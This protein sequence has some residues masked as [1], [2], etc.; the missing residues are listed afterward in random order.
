MRPLPARGFPRALLPALQQAER[1]AGSTCA[2]DD[3]RLDLTALHSISIDDADTV[4]VD[5]AVAL[6]RNPSGGHRLWVHVADPEA[7]L[8]LDDPLVAEA[9]RRGSSAYLGHGTVPMFPESLARGVF[10][11]RPATRC[12]AFSFWLDLDDNDDP[13]AEGFSP[14]W[15][16]V[17]YGTTYQDVDELLELAPPQEAQLLTMARI[18]TRLQQQRR[19]VGA[20]VLEQPEARFRAGGDG[21]VALRVQEPSPARRLVAECMLAAGGIAGRYGQRHGLPLPYRSQPASALPGAAQLAACSPGAVRNGV[22]KACLQPSSSGTR[23]RPHSSLGLAAY[24]QVTSPIRRFTDMLAH[25]QLRAR[26]RGG[27]WLAEAE[28]QQWLDRSLVGIRDVV[29]L[30]KEDRRYWLHRWLQ[31]HG[32]PWRGCF[33]RWLRESEQ[34]GLAWCEAEALELPCYGTRGLR[35]DDPLL[36]TLRQVDPERGLLRIQAERCPAAS[37]A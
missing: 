23:P 34:L 13:V 22:I 3:Q 33:I 29:R 16:R 8:P 20:V 4:E 24:V 27:G 35:P 21:T 11:L 37:L 30:S 7:V 19:A 32:G 18:A 26:L 36:L 5:D 15:V 6:G 12:R 14:S 2:G 9:C 25:H 17:N 1:R 10:S 31:Q 28:L